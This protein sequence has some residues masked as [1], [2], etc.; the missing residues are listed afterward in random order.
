MDETAKDS[1]ITSILVAQ[2]QADLAGLD[3]VEISKNDKHSVCKIM[4]YN[5]FAF[6]QK[7]AKKQQ[8]KNA[9]AA[10]I[11]VKEIQFRPNTGEHDLKV[12]ARRA[13]EFLNAGNHVKVVIKYRGR[14]QSFIEKGFELITQFTDLLDVEIQTIIKPARSGRMIS[15]VFAAQ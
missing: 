11:K 13:T 1:K 12:K 5:K 15:A 7:Q 4:D 9:K 8:A 10:A 2:Q 3:L 14:E 6:A